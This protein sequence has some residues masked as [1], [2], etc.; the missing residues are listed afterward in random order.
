MLIDFTVENYASFRDETVLSAETG[1][2]LRK[3]KK[4]N[5]FEHN[6]F[7]LL[8]SL[9]LFG[10][11]GSGKTNMIDGL[12]RMRDMVMH[13]PRLVTD[14]LPYNPFRGDMNSRRKPQMFD[15]RFTYGDKSYHYRY[16][17]DRTE[18]IYEMLAVITPRKEK[19][20]FER[21]GQEYPILPER[22]A[23]AA[24]ATKSNTLFLYM[25]QRNNDKLAIEVV[26]WF[27]ELI[28]VDDLTVP[29][30]FMELLE[31]ERIK[32]ALVDFL[33]FADLSIIDF[34][35]RTVDAPKFPDEIKNLIAR[36]SDGNI[37]LPEKT[38]ELVT[39]HKVYE[40][41]RYVGNEEFQFGDESL[42]TRKMMVIALAIIYAKISGNGRTIVIDEFDDALHME[43][44]TAL[45]KIFNSEQGRNQFILTT[46]EL[47]LLDCDLRI[48]QIYLF[49]KD[50]Q[51]NSALNSI[52]DF[53]GA[54][55]SRMDIA[56]ARR[57]M[58]GRFG[59][60]PQVSQE[61]MMN[62][63]KNLEGGDYS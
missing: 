28:F 51:G 44:S 52:F 2:R 49:E 17:F 5:T 12:R 9:A 10:P 55:T 7:K 54:A 24:E 41:G 31:D 37:E 62:S 48:D 29:Q 6:G 19:I 13:D 34:K 1:E 56:F 21:I 4:T 30:R 47:E 46:H 36:M 14:K 59:A 16:S 53:E 45:L 27:Q 3:F 43:L 63:L 42:G 40:N 25:A 11:N 50:F 38:T 33:G 15:V 57:Y 61:E 60:V 58:E 32:R 39:I 23:D 22:L 26:R 8:K 18:I 20:Y 35:T